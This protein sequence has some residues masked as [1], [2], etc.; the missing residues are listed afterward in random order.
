MLWNYKGPVTLKKHFP[1]VPEV[2]WSY[3]AYVNRLFALDPICQVSTFV[4]NDHNDKGHLS[5]EH[6][7]SI[8]DV[9]F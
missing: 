4:S 5:N 2:P 8:G 7:K 6:V 3:F 1:K 9:Y